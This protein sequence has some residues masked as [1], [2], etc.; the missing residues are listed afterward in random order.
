MARGL[1]TVLLLL[2]QMLLLMLMEL[3]V[4]GD[5]V[6]HRGHIETVAMIVTSLGGG[7]R[8]VGHHLWLGVSQC[9]VTSRGPHGQADRRLF[10]H[11]LGC[12]GGGLRSAGG[13]RRD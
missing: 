3:G 7:G 1:G 11:G 4:S 9:L 5:M 13:L 10:G 2:L 8:H 6:R 12:R